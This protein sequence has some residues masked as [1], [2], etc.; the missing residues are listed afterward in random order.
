MRTDGF[1]RRQRA[2]CCP[3]EDEAVIVGEVISP[4]LICEGQLYAVKLTLIGQ[5]LQKLTLIYLLLFV[6]VFLTELS[7]NI[8]M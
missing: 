1:G 2:G 5:A 8:D 7:K 3:D 6:Y 4:N